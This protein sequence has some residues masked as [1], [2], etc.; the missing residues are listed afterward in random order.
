MHNKRE[1]YT[2]KGTRVPNMYER[3]EVG[4]KFQTRKKEPNEMNSSIIHSAFALFLILTE[5]ELLFF[6]FLF[7][8]MN[9]SQKLM[10]TSF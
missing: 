6:P 8:T 9:Y 1:I 10:Q 4:E 3:R 7:L 2:L 5:Y